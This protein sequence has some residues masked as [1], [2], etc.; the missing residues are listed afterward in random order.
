MHF[1]TFSYLPAM[2]NEQV[3]AQVRRVIANNLIPTI[4]Y[5]YEP[6]AYDS[7]WTMWKLPL[8]GAKSAEEVMAEVEECKKANPGAV[9]KIVGYDNIR[10]CQVMA[11]VVHK[12]AQAA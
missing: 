1:E 2:S 10:Q 8:W 6:D 7:Y 11:F 4:E 5:T 9:I 3:L 12:P